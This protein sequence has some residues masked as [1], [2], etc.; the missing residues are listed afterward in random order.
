MNGGR[1]EYRQ[2]AE[3][4]LRKAYKNSNRKRGL[5]LALT[6]GMLMLLGMLLLGF[7]Q[8]KVR[9]DQL[10]YRREN[11][12]VVDTYVE[13]GTEK[14]AEILK[15]FQMIR[16]IGLEKVCGKLMDNGIVYCE[17]SVMEE[18][19]WEKLK[20]AAYTDIYG[21]YPEEGNEIMLS[22]KTLEFLGIRQP[23]IGM[24]LS[25]E[26]HWD[27]VFIMKGTGRQS[28][29]L[30]GYYTDY[31]KD[32]SNFSTAYLSKK[33]LEQADLTEF[34]CRILLD[35]KDSLRSGEQTEMLLRES[36][37][38]GQDEYFVS[39]DSAFY[40]SA[41]GIAGSFG[42]GAFLLLLLVLCAVLLIYQLIRISFVRDVRQ[43]GT[44]R[45]I[46]VTV[47]QI[48]RVV[49][50][51][52]LWDLFKGTVLGGILSCLIIGCVFPA[53]MT[54]MYMG[55]AGEMENA[56]FLSVPFWAGYALVV[57]MIGFATASRSFHVLFR[58]N[59]AETMGLMEIKRMRKKKKRFSLPRRKRPEDLWKKRKSFLTEMAWKSIGNSRR[60]FAFSI[61]IVSLGGIA[62]LCT[63]SLTSGTDL[64]RKLEKNPEFRIGITYNCYDF[65]RTRES[66]LWEMD[67]FP[68]DL[69]KQLEKLAEQV[70]GRAEVKK[71]YLLSWFDTNVFSFAEE[72]EAGS[73]SD[74]EAEGEKKDEMISGL[75]R[76]ATDKPQGIIYVLSEEE[77]DRL[78]KRISS[79]REALKEGE[80]VLLHQ[81]MPFR[82]NAKDHW[83][84]TVFQVE[85]TTANGTLSSEAIKHVSELTV[86]ECADLLKIDLSDFDLFWEEENTCWMMVSEETFQALSEK[87]YQR[88]LEVDVYVP[89]EQERNAEEAIRKE[90]DRVNREFQTQYGVNADLV[91]LT[92]N[93]DVIARE[94]RYLKNSR[95][96]MAA[97][98]AVLFLLG[99]LTYASTRYMDL[100]MRE[101]E[102]KT[103]EIL[104]VT[105]KQQ[106]DMVRL[107]GLFHSV[108]I[109]VLLAVVGNGVIAFLDRIVQEQSKYF[110][111]AYPW[112][113]FMLLTVLL[114]GVSWIL[115][116]GFKRIR[117]NK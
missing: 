109:V 60:S 2:S 104:G 81:G 83:K 100:V 110:S 71:G 14:T 117:K 43:Y 15:N 77:E 42:I 46:G 69:R 47:K 61:L 39:E 7:I 58:T 35:M 38:L 23:E 33:K 107:E 18:Q 99:I 90:V 26:F 36:I 44:M 12:S 56:S 97:V 115:P 82:E 94:M 96:C 75:Y 66:D 113:A 101:K 73:A 86:L 9:A 4:L 32:A 70:E 68:E 48:R 16:Q 106:R 37:A 76:Y 22:Q 114:L 28:F 89:G 103:L 72:K 29:I 91:T 49:Y 74:S 51:Q 84:E 27:S 1:K 85:D 19:D 13:N 41:R 93:L 112:G 78:L 52:V 8:G 116:E 64:I 105:G 3:K 88:V 59:A 10:R 55:E 31:R 80:A 40:K 25:L 34:P 17:C 87:L 21:A 63:V 57:C 5:V 65:L 95:I 50:R 62:A 98:C 111:A 54:K 108:V 92:C 53:M 67:F 24:E 102:R 20:A 6:S 30:S 79:Q 11:G 45:T